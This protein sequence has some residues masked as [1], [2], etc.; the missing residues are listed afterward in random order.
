MTY[1]QEG[2]FRENDGG[3]RGDAGSNG[4]SYDVVFDVQEVKENTEEL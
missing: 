1:N 3:G 2:D 4:Q